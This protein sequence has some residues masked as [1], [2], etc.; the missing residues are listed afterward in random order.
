MTWIESLIN[1]IIFIVA[2]FLIVWNRERLLV[3]IKSRAKEQKQIRN[4]ER[5]AYI[6]E[7]KN[8]AKEKGS[9]KARDKVRE[10]TER[11]RW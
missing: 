1:F 2:I 4:I 3:W 9:K 5:K 11:I 7:M 6:A 10:R 8:I